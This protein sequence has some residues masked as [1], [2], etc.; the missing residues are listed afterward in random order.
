MREAEAEGREEAEGLAICRELAAAV[1]PLVRGVQ[2]A[3]PNGRLD[4]ALAVLD[5]IR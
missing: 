2:V 3:A 4:L 1:K 5:S